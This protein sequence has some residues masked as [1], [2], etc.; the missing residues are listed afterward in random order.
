MQGHTLGKLKQF[1]MIGN[2]FGTRTWMVPGFIRQ[3]SRGSGAGC[4]GF[5]PQRQLLRMVR[6]NRCGKTKH[7]VRDAGFELG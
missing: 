6:G 3:Q 1:M 5:S 7:N 4:R 2:A